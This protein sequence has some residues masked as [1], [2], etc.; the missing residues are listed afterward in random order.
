MS[1]AL[2]LKPEV[3][4][5]GLLYVQVCVPEQWTDE[6]IRIFAEKEN[7][8]GTEHGWSVRTDPELLNGDPARNKCSARQGYIHVTL[9][10]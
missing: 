3:T 10:C 9:D 1:E 2:V 5:A 4:R 6:E 8:C 7:P